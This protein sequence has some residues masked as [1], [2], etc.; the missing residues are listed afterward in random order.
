MKPAPTRFFDILKHLGPGIIIAGSIVG[1]GELIATTL[2]GAKTGFVLLWLIV[3]GC[4]IKVFTLI[5]FGRNTIIHSTSPLVA[6]NEIPGPK[7]KVRWIIWYWFFMIVLIISQQGGILGATSQAVSAISFTNNEVHWLNNIN[8]LSLIIACITALMLYFGRFSFI[9]SFSTFLVFLFTTVTLFNVAYLQFI[10]GWEISWADIKEGF[11]MG[12]PE[13][14]DGL[15]IALAAFGLI[16]VGSSEIIMYPYWCL[17]KGYAKFTGPFQDTPEW[18]DNAKGW[19]KVLQIDAWLSLVVYTVT[20][21][22]FYLLGAS[23]LHRNELLPEENNLITTLGEMYVPVFGLW[24]KPVFYVGA[25]AVLYSTFFVAAAGNARVL[26]DSFA[27][28]GIIKKD[29]LTHEKWTKILSFAWPIAALI[30]FLFIQAP[31]SM[32]IWSGIAQAVMLPMLAFAALYFRYFKTPQK[33]KP[34]FI[35]QIFLIIS[36]IGMLIVAIWTLWSKW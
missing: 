24:A 26:A 17:E 4:V 7:L 8:I 31:K 22:A 36:A 33:L 34:H 6:L 15:A 29:A 32:I 21:V 28:V 5:E 1:S 16:G 2:V 23:I 13:S 25:I 30:L 18:H 11:S 12:I 14:K 27:L 9:Q 35:W 3:L 10:P 19:I 20:T